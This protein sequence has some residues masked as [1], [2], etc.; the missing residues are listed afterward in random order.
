MTVKLQFWTATDV[1]TNP[2]RKLWRLPLSLYSTIEHDTSAVKGRIALMIKQARKLQMQGGYSK[3]GL[4]M[5]IF[6]VT[7]I[8]ANLQ[9]PKLPLDEATIPWRGRLKFRTVRVADS[10]IKLLNSLPCDILRLQNDKS[11]FNAALGRC[12]IIIIII[13]I[14]IHTL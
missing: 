4:C 14:I 12:V 1:P 2:P 7:E 9:P 6:F 8:L 13:I 11:N 3:Y 5:N 10:R